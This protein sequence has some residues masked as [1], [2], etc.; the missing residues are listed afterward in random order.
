V[1]ILTGA[2]ACGVFCVLFIL[3]W[4]YPR[5]V[6]NDLKAEVAELKAALEAERAA[7]AASVTAASATKDILA[8]IQL[9]QG[10]ATGSKT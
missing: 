1:S 7:S 9:G 10:M 8:A 2:G 3:G 4:I 5:T 6:V